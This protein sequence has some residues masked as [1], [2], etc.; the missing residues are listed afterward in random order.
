VSRLISVSDPVSDLIHQWLVVRVAWVSM[1]TKFS[2]DDDYYMHRKCTRPD[3]N[4]HVCDTF[5]LMVN[6]LNTLNI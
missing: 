3:E 5:P 2:V 1:A 4:A 6:M